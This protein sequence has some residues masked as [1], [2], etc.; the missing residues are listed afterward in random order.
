MC[1]LI[2]ID[3]QS[4]NN[5]N[6]RRKGNRILWNCIKNAL[7]LIIGLWNSHA[8]G[9]FY[10]STILR[11]P[12]DRSDRINRYAGVCVCAAFLINFQRDFFIAI[13]PWPLHTRWF[14]NW[15]M[16]A[17][18][19]CLSNVESNVESSSSSSSNEAESS[20]DTELAAMASDHWS[21]YREPK[22]LMFRPRQNHLDFQNTQS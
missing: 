16:H 14:M 20:R 22:L 13:V 6:F 1:D 10:E 12:T 5:S 15:Q 17:K 2:S 18:T 21:V 8:K 4:I 19:H 3:R 9:K 11:R 7:I